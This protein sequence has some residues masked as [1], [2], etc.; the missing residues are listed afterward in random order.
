MVRWLGAGIDALPT[1]LARVEASDDQLT[2]HAPWARWI[3]H[4]V[5]AKVAL[6]LACLAVAGAAVSLNG[7]NTM[8]TSA[9]WSFARQGVGHLA[10]AVPFVALLSILVESVRYRGLTFAAVALWIFSRLLL[11]AGEVRTALEMQD[12]I[13]G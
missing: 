6:G 13:A 10:N 9:G 11:A 12:I 8:A 5:W 2:E 3:E 7:G 1:E 4:G